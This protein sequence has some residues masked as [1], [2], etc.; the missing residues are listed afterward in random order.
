MVTKYHLYCNWRK[1][2]YIFYIATEERL[3]RQILCRA[4]RKCRWDSKRNSFEILCVAQC[5]FIKKNNILELKTVRYRKCAVYPGWFNK[6]CFYNF[7]SHTIKERTDLLN[8]SILPLLVL[9]SQLPVEQFGS[10]SGDASD[11][12]LVKS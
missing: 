4:F 11:F 5:Q 8:F 3:L 10:I 12:F 6:A 1:T 7:E 9:I 2:L